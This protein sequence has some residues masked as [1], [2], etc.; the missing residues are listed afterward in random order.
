MRRISRWTGWILIL[1]AGCRTDSSGGLARYEF[2]R[3][4]M[5]LPFR[6]VLYAPDAVTAGS[7]SEAAFGRIAELNASLSDYD[8]DSELSRL[9]RTAGSGRWVPLGADLARVLTTAEGVSRASEG[10]FD[11][12]VGPLIQLWKRARRQRE[13]PGGASLAAARQVTGWTNLCLRRMDAGWEARLVRAGMRLDLGGI[14]KGY[15]LDEAARVLR[16][17]GVNR[18]LISGGGDMVAGEPPPDAR[19]WR[20]EIGVFDA[21]EAPA[22]RFV[23]LKNVALAT[24]GDTFQRAEIGGRRYSHIVDPRTGIGLTDHGLVT[25]IGPTGMEVDA[26]S[27]VFSVLG[28]ER[29]WTLARPHG[30]QAFMLRMPGDRVEEWQSPGFGRW[31]A[32]G[33]AP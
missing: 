2:E 30:V 22:P 32:P 9:S 28:P 27:K 19:A 33:S 5:G 29:A 12:T 26:L 8:E 10:A 18:Y 16:R 6:M 14:A 15:A 13:L 17:R 4:E 31:W 25:V 20:V 7:A 11:V 21:P 24:S 3:P 23:L 1:L